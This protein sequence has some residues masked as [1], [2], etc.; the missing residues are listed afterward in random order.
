[1]SWTHQVHIRIITNEGNSVDEYGQY[2]EY[3]H[4]RGI[5]LEHLKVPNR[6]SDDEHEK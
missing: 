6:L 2:N 3:F 5:R 1:M 4:T